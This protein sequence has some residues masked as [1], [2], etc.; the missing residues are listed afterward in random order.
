MLSES[1]LA[2]SQARE[3]P[4]TKTDVSDEAVGRNPAVSR[5]GL[6]RSL[7]QAIENALFQLTRFAESCE[8]I[9]ANAAAATVVVDF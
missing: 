8:R 2:Q 3:I 1:R 9:F 4:R 7:E 6:R 5:D